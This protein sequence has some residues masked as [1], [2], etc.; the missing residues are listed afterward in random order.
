[1]LWTVFDDTLVRPGITL[2]GFI[3]VGSVQSGHYRS[4]D[5][6]KHSGYDDGKGTHGAHKLVK[7][8]GS[9]RSY[10]MGRRANRKAKGNGVCYFEYF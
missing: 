1:M 10:G 6:R 8:Y 7:L 3:F 9:G 4:D 5:Y 2:T